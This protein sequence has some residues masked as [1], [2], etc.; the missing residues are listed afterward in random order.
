M[1]IIIIYHLFQHSIVLAPN[2]PVLSNIIAPSLS[3]LH[4]GVICFVLISGYW[5]IKFSLRSFVK[6]VVQCSFYAIFIYSVYIIINPEMFS[7]KD[8]IS[9]LYQWWY[10][11]I[12]LC[13][14]L[15]T[16]IINIPLRTKSSQKKLFFIAI[17]GIISI[18]FGLIT[19]SLQDGKNPLN[20]VL[21]YYIGNFLRNDLKINV[22]FNVLKILVLYVLVNFFLISFMIV[23]HNYFPLISRILV[24][25]FYPYNSI[26][27]ILVSCLFFLFFIKIKVKS[28]LINWIATSTLPV[29]LLH[30]TKYSRQYL[31]QLI[32]KLQDIIKDHVLYVV[33]L[34]FL[35]IVILF[36][37]V[38][39]DKLVSPLINR[40][41]EVLI[42]SGFLV[43]GSKKIDV[44]L[45]CDVDNASA[46]K[47]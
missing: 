2:D 43:K 45:A 22:K 18:G 9:S 6:L 42:N 26:G 28:R 25:L 14:Y 23:A 21:I 4:I 41:G 34:I 17:L 3:A 15:L 24:K 5:G 46:K 7:I 37:C 13:L 33:V 12:Y 27:L 29:Y 19:P 1:L 8:L 35:A 10:I 11:R 44:L 32:T 36:V 30:E 39:I 20:F 38:L 40:V 31:Y 47:V 16:P